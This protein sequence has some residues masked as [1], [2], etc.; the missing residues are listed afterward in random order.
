[1]LE[2]KIRPNEPIESALKRLKIKVIESGLMDDWYRSRH[3]ET[4]AQKK[5]RKLKMAIKKRNFLKNH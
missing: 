2:V 3:F 4:P 5:A 1:M